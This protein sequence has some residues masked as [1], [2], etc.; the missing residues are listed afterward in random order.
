MSQSD[1]YFFKVL[2]P[3]N[4]RSQPSFRPLKISVAAEIRHLILL[5]EKLTTQCNEL[6][7][8]RERECC[9]GEIIIVLQLTFDCTNQKLKWK[10]EKKKSRVLKLLLYGVTSQKK[11]FSS[12]EIE[13]EIT[14]QDGASEHFSIG[15]PEAASSSQL[16][17]LRAYST[18]STYV[19]GTF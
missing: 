4:R 16:V 17:L 15:S 19:E 8:G 10:W 14:N 3:Q 12:R 1:F 6:K 5:Q 9:S 11:S 13:K 7:G 2:T 18:P